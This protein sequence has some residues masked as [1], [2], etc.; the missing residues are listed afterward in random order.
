M[1]YK[2]DSWIVSVIW[3]RIGA[4]ILCIVAFVLGA[5]GYTFAPEDIETTEALVTSVLS[6]IGGVL[7]I[8]SKVRES[9]KIKGGSHG[10][11][12]ED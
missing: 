12:K 2:K 9:K 7:V 11:D 1:E 4:A 8:V 10:D 3:G 5:L 6:G